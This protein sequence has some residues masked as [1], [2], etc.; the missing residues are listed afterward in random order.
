MTAAFFVLLMAMGVPIVFVLGISALFFCL[1]EGGGNL[2]IFA[3]RMF[4]GVNKSVLICI[5]FFILAGNLMNTG[6]I[7]RRLV[8]FA[9]CV[10]GW[11]RGGLAMVSVVTGMIFAGITGSGAAD[12]AAIGSVLIPAMK[13]EKYDEDFTCALI[14][15][16]GV[17]GPIIPPSITFVIFAVV[18]EVS[19]GAMFLGGIVPGVLI[20]ISLMILSYY[21]ARRRNYPRRITPPYAHIL[22]TSI[23]ALPA[24][25]MPVLIVGSILYGIATPTEASA[26]SVLYGLILGFFVYKELKLSQL[27]KIIADTAILTAGIMIIIGTSVIFAWVLTYA[28]IPQKVSAYMLSI[29][30]NPLVFLFFLNILLLFLG[31]WMDPTPSIIVFVPML[32]P[33]AIALGIHP[34]HF[35]LVFSVNVIIGM[36]TPPV[37]Y[38][39]YTVV[40]MTGIKI[41]KLSKALFPFLLVEILVLFLITYI[42]W[43]VLFLPKY[44]GYVH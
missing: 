39:L 14:T 34:I 35:G 20:G 27:P 31:T 30:K 24:I 36:A 10:V 23:K 11:I 9:M 16:V 12:A 2:I 6:G 4:V 41:E 33:T 26:A 40:A 44:F 28:D 32:M 3:Q 8:D 17:I 22:K 18:G 1:L 5:P 43:I 42:P 29:S 37:G 21:Y 25:M 15:A 13:S 38:I 19:I 7:T